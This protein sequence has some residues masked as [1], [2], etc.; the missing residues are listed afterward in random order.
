VHDLLSLFRAET[1]IELTV[2]RDV[3]Y[4]TL[5]G[6]Q[7][8]AVNAA[9]YLDFHQRHKPKGSF[10]WLARERSQRL[11]RGGIAVWPEAAV[12]SH[13][14]RLAW[15]DPLVPVFEESLSQAVECGDSW[16]RIQEGS[17]PLFDRD[18]LSHPF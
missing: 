6:A 15:G 17:P 12:R 3:F 14:Y 9:T 1:L 13:A 8:A 2:V 5:Y 18:P 16:F 4:D 10:W 7:T 11:F